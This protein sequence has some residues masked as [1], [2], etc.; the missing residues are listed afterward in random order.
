MN[1]ISTSVDDLAA[2]GV[3]STGRPIGVLPWTALI[4]LSL[5]WLGLTAI[6]SLVTNAMQ[7]RLKFGELVPATQIGSSLAILAALTFGFSFFIQPTV[8]AISDYTTSRWGRRKPYIVA[9]ALLDA[10]FLIGI[11][12]DRK[13]V[14]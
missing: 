9:G 3:G 10:V 11:A 12:T 13:S 2:A 7:S 8:G 6:D 1:A 4:R 5:F 14:V